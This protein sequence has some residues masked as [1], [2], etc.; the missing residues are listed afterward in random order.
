MKA[1]LEYSHFPN[2]DCE[3]PKVIRGVLS[4]VDDANDRICAGIGWDDDSRVSTM[5]M[6]R[7]PTDRGGPYDI[8]SSVGRSRRPLARHAGPDGADGAVVYPGTRV[9]AAPADSA[10][11]AAH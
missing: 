7:R 4:V 11:A 6:S 10:A 9:D 2:L 3:F 8:I 5:R 1:E